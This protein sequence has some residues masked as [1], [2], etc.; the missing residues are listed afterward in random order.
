MTFDYEFPG[1]EIFHVIEGPL[2]IEIAGGEAF[3]VNAGDIISFD[4]GVKSIWTIQSSFKKF[5][6]I[7]NC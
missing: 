2:S 5:F 3:S 7:Y 1:D 6:V 4:K